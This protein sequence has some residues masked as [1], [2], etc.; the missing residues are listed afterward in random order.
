V[1]TELRAQ[2]CVLGCG[3]A[4]ITVARCLVAGGA[5]VLVVESGQLHWDA[6]AQALLDGHAEGPVIKDFPDYL[7]DSRRCQV[8]GA[9]AGW[10][11]GP[12]PWLMDF[13]N[14]D[15]APQ[16]WLAHSGWPVTAAELAPYS[17]RA[18]TALGI[19]AFD[20]PGRLDGAGASCRLSS[21]QYHF[22]VEPGVLRADFHQLRRAPNCRVELGC[23]VLRL[24]VED[25][26]VLQAWAVA[27][28][29]QVRIRADR[30]VL[31]A[32]GVENSRLLL[33]AVDRRG[34]PAGL[35]LAP[36]VGRFFMEHFHVVAGRV[37]VPVTPRWL[38]Y[39]AGGPDP[40]LGHDTL[41]VLQLDAGAR[42]VERLLGASVQLGCRGGPGALARAEA[43]TAV[44]CDLFVRAE[45]APNPASRVSLDG[46]DL[47]A[48][49]R[50]RARLRW[51]PV[52]EDWNSI[53]RT[54]RLVLAELRTGFGLSGELLIDEGH[55][56]PARP[57]SPAQSDR[58]TWGHH[59]LGTTRMHDDPEHGAVD[60]NGRGHGAG[61]LYLAGSSVFATSGFANPTF[62]IVALAIRLADHLLATL[63]LGEPVGA[64]SSGRR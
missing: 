56:W 51:L 38:P 27:G 42:R 17:A 47:D 63:G 2:V 12:R 22:P 5:D 54:A 20:A 21:R 11:D 15:F 46:G 44:E 35:A 32:G 10:G 31:A 37:R 45:Q 55:P 4:G 28:G 58:P 18:A 24:V 50:P 33:L 61:N 49:G 34:Q 3:P 8:G 39:L 53:V 43:G 62:L 19:A 9:G 36:A 6:A 1:T 40:A 57:A 30:F 59:H 48:Y 64:D 29:E 60:R 7:R 52:A 14:E 26:V 25:G 41:R 13:E 16:D 23:T